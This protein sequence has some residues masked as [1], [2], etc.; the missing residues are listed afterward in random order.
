MGDRPI[1]GLTGGFFAACEV[2][3]TGFCGAA[4]PYRMLDFPCSQALLPRRVLFI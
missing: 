3:G 4:A 1:L 2:E